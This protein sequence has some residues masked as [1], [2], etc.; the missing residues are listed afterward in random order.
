MDEGNKTLADYTNFRNLLFVLSQ[1]LN[2]AVSRLRNVTPTELKI[3]WRN[4]REIFDELYPN[5]NNKN[6]L[7]FLKKDE[8]LFIKNFY[9]K[10]QHLSVKN[11]VLI[12]CLQMKI[13]EKFGVYNISQDNQMYI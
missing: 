1:R 12:N 3:E 6:M 7:S 9:F 10:Q 11:A 13:M 8:R 5:I 4:F 2:K